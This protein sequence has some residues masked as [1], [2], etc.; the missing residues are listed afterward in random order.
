MPLDLKILRQW[1]DRQKSLVDA[2]RQLGMKP[3]N[4]CRLL[5]N[6]QIDVRL[7]TLEHLADVIGVEPAE[8]IC[9]EKIF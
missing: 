3:P 6:V 2:A 5:S 7:S 4:L 8:M 1:A 9:R